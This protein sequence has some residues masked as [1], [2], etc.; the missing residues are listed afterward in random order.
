MSKLGTSAD[1][2]MDD[3]LASI[4]RMIAADPA[5]QTNSSDEQAHFVKVPAVPPAP[6]PVLPSLPSDTLLE[7][8]VENHLAQQAVT[9]KPSLPATS[10]ERAT[11]ITPSVNPSLTPSAVTQAYDA[12]SAKLEIALAAVK[13]DPKVTPDHGHLS[14]E[15]PR[16]KAPDSSHRATDAAPPRLAIDPLDQTHRLNNN[17]SAYGATANPLISSAPSITNAFKSSLPPNFNGPPPATDRVKP[18]DREMR[19]T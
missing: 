18:F 3:I 15:Q 16:V 14:V 12:I 17:G 8:L 5:K 10:T 1:E 7:E 2:S 6:A 9:T 11:A 4:R 13:P 19:T